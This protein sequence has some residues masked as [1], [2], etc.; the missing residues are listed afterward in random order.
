M[1]TTILKHLIVMIH[2]LFLFNMKPVFAQHT[3]RTVKE[4]EYDKWGK[5]IGSQISE[6]GTWSTISISYATTDTVFLINN[7]TKQQ[8]SIAGVREGSFMKEN[9][10]L[11][12]KNNNLSV[13]NLKTLENIEIPAVKK[14]VVS[15]D[16]NILISIEKHNN[17]QRIVLRD[18]KGNSIKTIENTRN[19]SFDNE[20]N[21][22][23]YEK[24]VDT[25]VFLEYIDLSHP[26]SSN[27]VAHKEAGSYIN[28]K[29][30]D[31]GVVIL[32][33][34]ENALSSICYFDLKSKNL[35]CMNTDLIE[36][37]IDQTSNTLY[38]SANAEFI[39]FN[40]KKKLVNRTTNDSVE[41]WYGSDQL[42]YPIRK[43]R[44]ERG[45]TPYTWVWNRVEN[46]VKQIT[47]DELPNIHYLSNS[48]KLL[49]YNP[50]QNTTDNKLIND[51]DVYFYDSKT[52][53]KKRI[54]QEFDP[55]THLF[56]NVGQ[57]D[58][59]VYYYDNNWWWYNTKLETATNLTSSIHAEWDN[60]LLDEG[61]QQIAWGIA[62]ISNDKQYLY[63]YDTYDIWKI[64]VKTLASTK[65]TKGRESQQ[66]FRFELLT[67]SKNTSD[68]RLIDETKNNRLVINDLNTRIKSYAILKPNHTVDLLLTSHDF[69]Y[70]KLQQAKLTTDFIYLKE[71]YNLPPELWYKKDMKSEP[72]QLF[73]TNK[74]H[75]LY[76]WGTSELLHYTTIDGKKLKAAIFYPPNY[77]KGNVYPAIV[78]VY[79][80]L[81]QTVKEYHNPS[82]YNNIGFNV[83]NLTQQGY[84]VVLPDMVYD[85]GFTGA[86]ATNSV[87]GVLNKLIDEGVTEKGKI[88]LIGQSFGGYETNF[89]LTET[90]L[91][92]AAVTGASLFDLVKDY[93]WNE[94]YEKTESWRYENFQFRIK[95]PFFEAPELYIKNS[96][97]YHASRITTPILSWTGKNDTNV[98]PEQTLTIYTALR[99]LKKKIVMLRYPEARHFVSS[100]EDQTDL[101]RRIEQWFAFYLKNEPKSSWIK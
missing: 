49:L 33:Q 30:N 38:L 68:I 95:K 29:W 65:L 78:R 32:S 31:N 72:I 93:F 76:D 50:Y 86:S 97:L 19:Y 37:E 55:N 24:I 47:D 99:K 52:A 92:S 34:N 42:I 8:I 10:F 73:A 2:L 96:P 69:L 41:I 4:S 60:K 62:G 82:M 39:Y 3:H 14:Y 48:H 54:I 59:F 43:M 66:V 27:A 17:A 5:V 20:T 25:S 1:K 56:G 91:F 57:T 40:A 64:N 53:F 7:L 51:Y 15:M 98:P 44:D 13:L 61:Y 26:L 85:K 28:F 84:I 79:E 11:W 90:D 74:Q 35:D 70:T 22:M 100:K 101:T 89:I 83:S 67:K 46:T 81:S 45:Y 12:L 63:L 77:K 9:S 58:D 87:V 75:Y 80:N 94:P 88:G 18:I 71:A 23:V 36:N 6:K 16:K 21:R